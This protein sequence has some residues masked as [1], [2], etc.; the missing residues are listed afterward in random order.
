MNQAVNFFWTILCFIPVI[1]FWFGEGLTAWFYIFAGIGIFSLLL[2]AR[3]LQLSS[4]PKFYEGIGVR[5]IR[6]FV[7]DGDIVKR[8]IKKRDPQY[9]VIK[10]KANALRY[11]NTILM[12]ERYHL[13]SFV[14]FLLTAL[15]A[16]YNGEYFSGLIIILADIIYNVCPILLQQY[17]R[18]R[19]ASLSR[20]P[21]RN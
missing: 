14:F 10:N 15:Y 11:Q 8:F 5:F 21:G 7:Q 2:P 3:L 1:G 6:K 18:A 9:R 19:V 13:L 4:N 16:I 12:Y 20:Y 17:N